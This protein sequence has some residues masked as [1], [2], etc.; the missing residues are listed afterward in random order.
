MAA[1]DRPHATNKAAPTRLIAT[2]A[3][4]FWDALKWYRSDLQGAM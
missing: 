2:P 3:N 1:E 4:P